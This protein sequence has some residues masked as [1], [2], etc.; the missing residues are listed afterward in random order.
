LKL[1]RLDGI[2]EGPQGPQLASLH[3]ACRKNE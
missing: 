1:M 2:K 3:S